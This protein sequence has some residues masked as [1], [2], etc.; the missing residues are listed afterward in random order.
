[1][2]NPGGEGLLAEKAVRRESR[3]DQL[4]KGELVRQDVQGDTV[5]PEECPSTRGERARD[6]VPGLQMGAE[7]QDL[8]F[9]HLLLEPTL[10]LLEAPGR[11][12]GSNNMSFWHPRLACYQAARRFAPLNFA[13]LRTFD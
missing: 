3:L 4:G 11:R 8:S 5:D 13:V 7:N 1:M 12:R 6:L 9:M 10:G 2:S